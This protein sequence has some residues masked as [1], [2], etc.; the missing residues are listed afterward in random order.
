MYHFFVPGE[1]IKD[2][3]AVITGPDF[4][5]IA[6]VL[7][8]KTG[9]QIEI[10]DGCGHK[11]SGEIAEFKKNEIIVDLLGNFEVDSELPVKIVLFQGFPKSDK[12]EQIIQKCVELGV[13]EI[14][15]VMTSRTI[16]KLDEKKSD[17]KIERFNAIS[18]SAAKQSGRG[19]I[20][21]VTNVMSF[22]EALEYAKKLDKLIIPYE[23]AEEMSRTRD[24][25][26]S[27]KDGS[28]GVFIGPE[29]GFSEEEVLAA[30]DIRAVPVTLGKRIL[31]T[32]TAGMAVIAMLGYVLEK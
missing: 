4:N 9:E 5:H 29:G 27:I 19:I 20:P 18:L 7:R 17:K 8:M 6:N 28:I 14:V 11:Y 30:R 15:P 3:K 1:Q 31:R 21:E 26:N 12:M 16:V 23:D 2:N 24:V 13:H 10:L 22:R 25:F 32:E